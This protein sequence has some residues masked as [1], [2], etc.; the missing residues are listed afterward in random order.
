MNGKK[1]TVLV[2]LDA[3]CWEYLEPLLQ[4]GRMPRLQQLINAGTSGTMHSTMPPW[5]PTAWASLV[6]GKNPGKHGIFDMTWR[7][8]NTY[9]FT[10]T[11]ARIRAGTPFWQRL[12][13]CGLSVGLVNVPFTYPIESLNGFVV[14]GFGTPE[15]ATELTYPKEVLSWIQEKW[16]NYEPVVN[17]EFLQTASPAEILAKEI[18]H[19][20]QQVQIAIELAGRYQ[21][22]VLIINLL[23]PDHA[24]HKMPHMEQIQEAY[25]QSDADLADL[26]EAFRPD[27]V[28]L[29]SDHGSSRLKGDF[30]LNAWLRAQGYYMELE[31]N[32]DERSAALNWLLM[33]WLQRQRGWSGWGEKIFRRLV[34]ESLF[35]MPRWL[36]GKFWQRM[37]NVFPFAREHVFLSNLPDYSRT[38]VFPGS[39]YAGLL[40]LNVAG[41]ESTG[42]VPPE[43]SKEL[44]A[45]IAAKLLDIREPETGQSLFAN[46]YTSEELYSG[47]AAANAPDLIL[48]SYGKEWNIRSSK[49]ALSTCPAQHRYFV[50]ADNGRD[51]GWHSR[52][53]IFVFSGPDFALGQASC[54]G[55]LVDVPATLLHLYDVPVPED[56][57]GRVLTELMS[58]ESRERP[59]RS[60]PGDTVSPEMVGE[61]Y[62]DE[63][64]AEVVSHLRALGYVD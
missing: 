8:P 2:G 43:T 32:P 16:G 37:D 23:L 42:V 54:E 40:Y 29:L 62:T 64:A 27:N 21:V 5:T 3:A 48:D 59:I 7:R 11:N 31:N 60:Q 57:D 45:E 14:A 34:R 49:Y 35:R 15:S 24:N 13:D 22:D 63:E 44:A 53:G 39:A 28:M 19:Q 18:A 10:P 25:C 56:Y 9:Q 58:P 50:A 6:T 55:H 46:I 26:L 12:N 61:A 17:A 36:Q 20:R 1:K 38:R 30:L 41:R 51:F 47:P 4:D 52:D 33:Q